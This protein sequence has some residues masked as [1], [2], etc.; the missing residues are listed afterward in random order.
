VSTFS[1]DA[2]DN[3][4]S[5]K[6]ANSNTTTLGYDALNRL[7]QVTE[8][9]GSARTRYAYDALGR[10][11]SV[12]DPRSLVTRYANNWLDLPEKITSPDTGVTDKTY[13]AAGN[14]L[15]SRDARGQTTTYVYDD[16][17]RRVRATHAD[18]SVITFVYDQ[19]ANGKGRLTSMSDST[20]TTSW[21]YDGFGHVLQKKQVTGAVTLTTSWSYDAATGRLTGMTY[22]SGYKVVYS[23]DAGDRVSAIGLQPPGGTAA[24]LIDQIGYSPFGPVVSWRQAASNKFYRRSFDRDGRISGITSSTGNVLSYAFDAGSRITRITESGRAD[25]TF[26]YDRNNRLTRYVDGASTIAYAYDA[27]GNRISDDDFSYAIASTSNRIASRTPIGSSTAQTLFYDAAGGM[28]NNGLFQL[29]YDERN[30]LDR[31]IVGALTTTYGVNGLGERVAKDGQQAFGKVEFVYGLSGGLLGQYNASGAAAEEIVWLGDLPVGTIQGGAAYH[32]APDHLGAPH[33]IVN[34]ANGQ[35]WFWNHDPFGN[36]APT[37]AAG[38][39]HRLRFP[40]QIYDAETG[41]H[42]NGHRDYDPRLGRYVESDP[43]GLAGGINTYAYARNDPVNSIDPL[44]LDPESKEKQEALPKIDIAA[45]P[46][47]IVAEIMATFARIGNY[48]YGIHMAP[49]DFISNYMDM[50]DAN[51]IGAD[52]FFHCKANCLAAQRGAGG[53]FVGEVISNGRE[54]FDMN[55]KG[56]S[57]LSSVADQQANR[58]GRA[59]GAANPNQACTGLCGPFRP[60]GLSGRY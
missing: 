39:A 31:V 57:A 21:T 35:V 49:G 58:F 48:I 9:E 18:G 2:N 56:D 11:A 51:T 43:I 45:Q 34:S 17:N 47:D 7:E 37:A 16:L 44:G 19:G 28:E 29:R 53:Q 60:N 27:S 54:W 33:Q 40:G 26:S 12:T 14:V 3:L 5:V 30:R 38:F 20:G 6:D 4:L 23:Y 52:K 24:A 32:I 15:T 10:L 13:D 59:Q 36:G 1:Y 25:K 42:S 55:I 22:P 8:P 50:R 41:L 46:K